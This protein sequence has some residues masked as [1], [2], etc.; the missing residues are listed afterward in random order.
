MPATFHLI[1]G[2]GRVRAVVEGAG[3]C[4]RAPGAGLAEDPFAIADA[5]RYTL[6]ETD[7]AYYGWIVSDRTGRQHSDPIRLKADAVAELLHLANDLVR[8][9]RPCGCGCGVLVQ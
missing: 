2:S 7:G 6:P 3:F 9:Y 8:T 4:R 1:H 5:V